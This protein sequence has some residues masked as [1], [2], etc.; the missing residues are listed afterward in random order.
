MVSRKN[1]TSASDSV[2]PSCRPTVLSSS[3][4][5]S[6]ALAMGTSFG[7]PSNR[8]LIQEDTPRARDL[9]GLKIPASL[10]REPR[11]LRGY[12]PPRFRFASAS[13]LPATR[14][15]GAVSDDPQRRIRNRKSVV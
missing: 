13:R 7:G 2:I 12:A 15:A 3:G 4:V 6:F 11:G 9:S 10:A 5:G 1:A 8:G 14:D